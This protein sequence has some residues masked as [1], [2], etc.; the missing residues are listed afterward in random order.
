MSTGNFPSQLGLIDIGKVPKVSEL[1]DQLC[2]RHIISGEQR[3]VLPTLNSNQQA[4]REILKSVEKLNC[5][6]AFHEVLFL[7]GYE[8]IV[9]VAKIPDNPNRKKSL[10]DF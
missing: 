1:V 8:D 2:A 10:F 3:R 4:W 7:T 6:S 5:I 9:G